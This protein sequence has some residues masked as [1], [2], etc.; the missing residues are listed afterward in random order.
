MSEKKSR[1]E[2]KAKLEF[3][4]S[5]IRKQ[6]TDGEIPIGEYLPSE[7]I[8][9][10]SFDLSKNSV[11]K[12]LE[13]LVKEGLIVKKSRIGNLVVSNKP[14][15]QVILRVGYYPSL[16]TDAKFQTLVRCFEETYSH[17]KV[18]TI[19]LPYDHYQK[20][21]YDF[22]QN[23]MIDVVSINYNDY[24]GFQGNEEMMFE[25]LE[26]DPKI[27]S[28][29][30]EPFESK[31]NQELVFVKPFV[32]SPIVLCYNQEH[33]MKKNI[34]FPD[35]GWKWK[36]ALETANLLLTN[37]QD[38]QH[39]GLYFH[40][41]SMNRW[42]IFLLQNGVQFERY[43]NGELAFSSS[44]L[45]E[46]MNL[47]RDLFDRQGILQAFLSDS[48]RDAEKL[49]LEER[50]SMIVASYFSLNEIKE[51]S[52]PYDIAPL[53]YIKDAKTMLLII[54]F[55]INKHSTKKDAAKKF[56]EFMGLPSTQE[57][58]RKET[59]SIPSV[60]EIAEKTGGES[61]FKPSR[62]HLF[63]EIIPSYSLYTDLGLTGTVLSEVRNEL[64]IY[65]SDLMDDKIL[66]QRIKAILTKSKSNEKGVSM[67]ENNSS[68]K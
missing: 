31:E 9:T 26:K 51:H 20:T 34:A 22:F 10:K 14:Y 43:E 64:R 37:N 6:I 2:F 3:M 23:D 33:F 68:K 28:F 67:I 32:F 18:Q 38:S 7:N 13:E 35:S 15:D 4:V 42:P 5:T 48:D 21:V 57:I 58:I 55:S 47:L 25:A 11:R 8:L 54:G 49:F 46:S 53:P 56:V 59:L 30:E 16:L 27:Y 1:E 24:V 63:R 45:T 19:P 66:H 36:Q 50:V 12:G 44:K 52:I 60:K 29:L 65:L 62:Y 17:I 40:P 61:V 41:L 39:C